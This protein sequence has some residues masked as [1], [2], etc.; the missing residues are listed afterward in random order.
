MGRCHAGFP[1]SASLG[2]GTIE[3][4]IG[5][6]R[7]RFRREA[8]SATRA[9]IALPDPAAWAQAIPPSAKTSRA[10]V[11]EALLAAC[12]DVGLSCEFG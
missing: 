2:P 11:V 10:E 7:L 4:C 12:K 9:R 1:P 3:L 5:A 8:L 6:T